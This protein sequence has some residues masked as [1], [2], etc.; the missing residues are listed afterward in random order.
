[1]KFQ[2]ILAVLAGVTS[3][4][5]WGYVGHET[6]AYVATN[7]V[8]DSTKTFFQDILGDTSDDYLA[9]VAAWADEYKYTDAGE[10]S[11]EFH[12]IDAN[13]DPPS[14]CGVEYSRDCAEDN[15]VVSAIMNYTSR[16]TESSIS[17]TNKAIAAKVF[18][19]P[20]IPKSQLRLTRLSDGSPREYPLSLPHSTI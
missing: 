1:M 11:K 5:A 8:A 20:K 10:F 13:D 9:S 6:V 2:Q 15:C 12:Y 19:I 18:A 17:A 14:S 7:F 3:V 4:S 16:L